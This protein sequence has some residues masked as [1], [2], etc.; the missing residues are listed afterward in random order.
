MK[1]IRVI[2]VFLLFSC[3]CYGQR[4]SVSYTRLQ[5]DKKNLNTPDETISYPIFKSAKKF[6]ADRI[7]QIVKKGFETT[8]NLKPSSISALLR[9]A[10]K[11]SLTWMECNE[12]RNDG[13]IFSFYLDFETEAAYPSSFSR[14]YCFDAVTGKLLTL[15]SLIATDK[16]KEFLNML[17][18]KQIANI[19]SYKKDFLEA[20]KKGE[21]DKD[22][23]AIAMD[24]VKNYCWD[25]YRSRN[26]SIL[27]D[28]MDIYIECG[29]A[30]AFLALSPNETITVS[31][32]E[33]KKYLNEKYKAL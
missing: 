7:N 8:F 18:Q 23:L 17:K 5:P 21:R 13:A 24:Y 14:Y 12:T 20:V 3:V 33:M 10:A 25:N 15:E 9:T 32:K 19:E 6:V 16:R 22:D 26:F 2:L 31:L 27:K 11:G 1:S 4:I 30:H 29:F 28:R